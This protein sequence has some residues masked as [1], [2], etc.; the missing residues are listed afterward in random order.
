MFEVF[1]AVGFEEDEQ[2]E[3]PQA[4]DEAVRGVPVPLLGFLFGAEK[5]VN[6]NR[7]DGDRAR[8]PRPHSRAIANTH[9]Y[10][11]KSLPVTRVSAGLHLNANADQRCTL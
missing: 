2:D 4:E 11:F 3:R 1:D 8:F 6:E 9:H 5:N 10:T 7:D